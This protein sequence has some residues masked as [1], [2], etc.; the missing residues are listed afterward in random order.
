MQAHSRPEDTAASS[1]PGTLRKRREFLRVAAGRKAHA[2]LFTVQMR[3]QDGR[4]EPARVGLT[5][6]KKVGG[7]VER[8]RI[9][10]RLREV[11]RLDGSL[12]L[13]PEHDYVIVARRDLLSAGFDHVAASL[14]ASIA[15][16]HGP[17]RTAGD[18]SPS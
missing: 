8:N 11:L 5:V 10:R 17:V 9:R 12:G 7:A 15:K 4:A 14:R 1:R 13:R 2:A 3:R 16:L 6:T 18:R